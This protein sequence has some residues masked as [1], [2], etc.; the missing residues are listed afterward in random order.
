MPRYALLAGAL[1]IA[2]PAF[3][4]QTPPVQTPP[5]QTTP[6]QTRP[7]PSVNPQ[8]PTP[9]TPPATTPPATTPAAPVADPTQPTDAES[10][11]PPR[12]AAD[13]TTVEGSE[14]T[15]TTPATQQVAPAATPQAAPAATPQAAPAP[16]LA[17]PAA[18][19][20]AAGPATTPG[21][22]ASIVDQ[23]FPTYDVDKD[24]ALSQAEFGTWMV[25]LKKKSD[26]ATTADSPATLAWLGKAFAQADVDRSSS[27]SSAELIAFLNP[28][29]AQPA[30]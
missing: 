6:V 1:T 16:A 27:L 10:D 14:D 18:Q 9:P 13:T 15:P 22:I 24:G 8:A 4:Q 20:A 25:A 23:E 2:A 3:A 29:P 12:S 26:P 19:S 17:A 30:S 7:A 11:L 28:A 21:Q 5:V